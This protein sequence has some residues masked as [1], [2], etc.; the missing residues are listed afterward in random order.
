M[1]NAFYSMLKAFFGLQMFRFL[2]WLSHNIGKQLDKKARDWTTK[3][4]CT[5]FPISQE[6]K[7]TR[8]WNMASK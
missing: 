1:K 5:Y 6:V 8:Q 7:A 4:T 2:S 3:I